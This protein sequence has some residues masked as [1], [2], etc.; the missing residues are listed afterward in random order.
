MVQVFN[1]I[2]GIFI[3]ICRRQLAEAG[4]LLAYLV[5]QRQRKGKA[6]L[7][8]NSHQVQHR[9]GA[10]AKCHIN[11]QGIVNGF[12]A[13][14]IT[15]SDVVRQQPHYRAPGILCQATPS[16]IHRRDGAIARQ[17]YP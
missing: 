15:G 13:E 5:D 12:L 16:G 3:H 1:V 6:R 2:F 8:S 4:C 7:V 10:G 17:A 9:V 14:E 11:G